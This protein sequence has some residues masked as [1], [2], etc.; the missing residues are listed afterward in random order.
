MKKVSP[1]P[2]SDA[3]EE[4]LVFSIALLKDARNPLRRTSGSSIVGEE[5]AGELLVE[6]E[7]M[8]MGNGEIENHD[9][10]ASSADEVCGVYS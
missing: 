5:E 8:K 10:K 1:P 7:L 4:G 3:H 9:G 2:Q 6:E